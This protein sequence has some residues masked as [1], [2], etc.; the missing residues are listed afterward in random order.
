MAVRTIFFDYDGTLHNG[1][2]IYAPAF[3][4]AY[5][6]LVENY[7]AE[8]REWTDREISYWLGFAPMDMWN[9]F[10]PDIPEETKVTCSGIIS[11]TM[12]AL[13]EEGKAELYEGSV[14]VL[15]YLREK[16]YHLIFISNC[17]S[18]YKEAH[19]RMFGLDSYFEEL[20]ATEDYGFQPKNEIIRA[21]KDRCEG[22]LAIVGDRLQD[23]EAGRD[24]GM[25]TIGC[26]YGY[27]S[28]AELEAADIIIGDILELKNFL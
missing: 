9:R 8:P 14:E 16:G 24:N 20:I 19:N 26:S 2:K 4:E 5:A 15:A 12:K 17:K 11:S 23:M 6:Y 13:T 22:E 21:I 1:L 10:M 28:A 25:L 27:G 3:R 18:Y 7:L